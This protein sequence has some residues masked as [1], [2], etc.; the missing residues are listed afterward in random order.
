ML[1][2]NNK[3]SKNTPSYINRSVKKEMLKRNYD[4]EDLMKAVGGWTRGGGK[5]VYFGEDDVPGTR[6]RAFSRTSP[7]LYVSFNTH[8]QGDI[9]QYIMS[10]RNMD[11]ND[12]VDYLYDLL[13]GGGVIGTAPTN[14]VNPNRKPTYTKF[15][16]QFTDEQKEVVELLKG[17]FRDEH[18]ET[19]IENRNENP[20]SFI[21]KDPF[22][23]QVNKGVFGEEV[24]EK[25]NRIYSNFIVLPWYGINKELKGLQLRGT[26]DTS[27]RYGWSIYTD[28]SLTEPNKDREIGTLF[29]TEGLFKARAL[30]RI[31]FRAIALA[32]L[33]TRD[34]LLDMLDQIDNK[35]KIVLALDND[36]FEMGEENGKKDYYKMRNFFDFLAMLH[37]YRDENKLDMEIKTA[38]FPLKYKGIDDYIYACKNIKKQDI[39]L[40]YPIIGTIDALEAALRFKKNRTFLDFDVNRD[41][42]NKNTYSNIA[43]AMTDKEIW[44][45][46]NRLGLYDRLILITSDKFYQVTEAFN[47]MPRQEKTT[48]AQN[49]RNINVYLLNLVL[50][51]IV[52]RGVQ[53]YLIKNMNTPIF[54]NGADKNFTFA[55][56]GTLSNNPYKADLKVKD[57]NHYIEVL[58]R[59]SG[60]EMIKAIR[61]GRGSKYKDFLELVKNGSKVAIAYVDLM[62]RKVVFWRIR[63]NMKLGKGAT[64]QA[65]GQKGMSLDF[66]EDDIIRT[67]PLSYIF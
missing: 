60:M 19:Y 42:N 4:F 25:M 2:I 21:D 62:E 11:F 59:C 54:K 3:L 67:I 12:A 35:K 20:L 27:L 28:V 22:M 41:K 23:E 52:E 13:V 37:T 40:Q 17:Q 33:T 63:K 18:N 14:P 32:S 44:E 47:Y 31:G 34:G 26:D 46:S 24:K 43:S 39:S 9:I 58:T 1:L 45:W 48:Y 8:D 51:W 29:I 50:S 16:H 61:Q 7:G 56:P 64:P 10:S 65:P 15:V 30:A 6:H 5:W 66:T 49:Y 36:I 57:R 38:L 53:K 55:N